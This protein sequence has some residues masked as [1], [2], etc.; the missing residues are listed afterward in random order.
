MSSQHCFALDFQASLSYCGTLARELRI[1]RA[2][3]SQG[4]VG[5]RRRSFLEAFAPV[6]HGRVS[7]WS[8]SDGTNLL[9]GF[10]G[11]PLL[12]PQA[13]W[14]APSLMRIKTGVGFTDLSRV[15]AIFD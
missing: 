1:V 2:G 12:S 7:R 8:G 3:F 14:R 15:Q 9:V 5:G 11:T 13:K 6:Q 10:L 4:A